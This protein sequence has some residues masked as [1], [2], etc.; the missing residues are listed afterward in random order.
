MRILI[1]NWKDI[2]NP[3]SGGAEVATHALAKIWVQKGHSVTLLSSSF[4]DAKDKEQLD[5][6][7]IIR[8]GRP[9]T[10]HFLWAFWYYQ[11]Y[12]KG[13]IDIVIDQIHWVPFFTPLYVK[14]PKVALIFEIAK[15]LWDINLFFPLSTIGHLTE[16]LYLALYRQIPFL[17]AAQS[18]YDELKTS[19]IENVTI[20]PLATNINLPPAPYPKE[21]IR[22][23]ISLNRLAPIKQIELTIKAFYLLSRNLDTQLWI[24]G[25][26]EQK[27]ENKM[28]KLVKNLGLESKIT[29]YGYVNEKKKTELLQRAWIITS[30]SAREGWGLNIIEAGI[31][32]TPAVVYNSPGLRNAVR[33]YVTGIV[34]Q[35]NTPECLASNLKKIITDSKLREQ[36]SLGAQKWNRQY[37]WDKSA[38]IT[39]DVLQSIAFQRPNSRDPH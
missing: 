18:T 24:V 25:R 22:T 28:K 12:L 2:N 30:T 11:R 38:K 6:V 27:Y 20:F 31:C 19:R 1:F 21:K 9:E 7:N 35:E 4:P 26:G 3:T 32:G 8:Q 29:F 36:L 10:T 23:L 39:L 13:K 15:N 16:T 5:G 17:T 37:S 34:C 33:N 14:E